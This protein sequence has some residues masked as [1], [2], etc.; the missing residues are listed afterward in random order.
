[1]IGAWTI[2]VGGRLYGPFTSERMRAFVSEGRLAPH[3]L[4]AR[5]NSN[6]WH[7]ARD[8]PVFADLF[9][10]AGV[11]SFAPL[12]APGAQGAETAF[13]APTGAA[14]WRCAAEP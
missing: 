8:E 2:N 1:M 13:P 6:D 14:G 9:A 3:S 7:E 11:A 4:V 12:S 10:G 5:E